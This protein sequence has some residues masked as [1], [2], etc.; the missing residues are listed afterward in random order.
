MI[1]WIKLPSLWLC[2][3]VSDI[4]FPQF[5]LVSGIYNQIKMVLQTLQLIYIVKNSG[6]YSDQHDTRF[7]LK[8]KRRGAWVVQ[9]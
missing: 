1:L 2:M 4:L 8:G 3:R 6:L 5:L 9:S 7:N